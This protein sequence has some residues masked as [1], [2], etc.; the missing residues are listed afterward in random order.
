MQKK[1]T[2]SFFALLLSFGFSLVAS[3]QTGIKGTITDAAGTPLF[4]ASVLVEGL[5]KGAVSNDNGYYEIKD[6]KPIPFNF[7]FFYKAHPCKFVSLLI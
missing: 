6:L 7:T 4:N 1:T 2:S 3:A 5:G